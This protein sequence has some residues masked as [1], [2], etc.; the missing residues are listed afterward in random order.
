M[1]C[2]NRWTISVKVDDDVEKHFDVC[3]MKVHSSGALIINYHGDNACYVY[4]P[5][6]WRTVFVID[7]TVS[8]SAWY[9]TTF[10]EYR[11][12]ILSRKLLREE[13]QPSGRF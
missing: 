3:F 9:R 6:Y 2:I 1:I 13:F 7:C 5:G 4:A 11:A 12:S 8:K 10:S